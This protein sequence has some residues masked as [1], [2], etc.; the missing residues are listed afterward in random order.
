V[1][2][3]TATPVDDGHCF[4]C[5]PKSTIGLRMHFEDAGEGAVQSVV[6]LDQ[7]Y[8]GW[9]G[10]AHGGIVAMLLDEAMA[11]AA[12]SLGN[13]GMTAELKMRFRKA[14][15]IGEPLLVRGNVTWQ[16]RNVLGLAASVALADG[17]ELASGTGSFVVKGKLAPGQRLGELRTASE[18]S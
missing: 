18:A 6:T 9:S 15:P 10:I 4:A 2:P 3:Q 16:R 11:Y 1:N 13:L 7:P 17:S 14:V 8:Q 5:G 12:G